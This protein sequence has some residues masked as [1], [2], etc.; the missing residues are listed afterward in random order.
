MLVAAQKH[1]DGLDA[2]NGSVIWSY[3]HDGDER[4][5][6]GMSIVPVPAGPNRVFLMNKQD[7]SVML[8]LAMKAFHPGKPPFPLMQINLWLCLS[9]R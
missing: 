3:E 6:G 4:A 5:M 9:Q 1:I 7:S 8:H 2:G